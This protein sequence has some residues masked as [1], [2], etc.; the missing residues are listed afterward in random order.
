[1][2][3]GAE[4][5]TL[6]PPADEP[7]SR[8][9]RWWW[10]ALVP[11]VAFA[12]LLASGLGRD[13]SELPSEL[14]GRSAPAFSLPALSGDTNVD[15]ATLRGNVVVVNFWASWCAECRDEHPALLNAWDRYRDRGVVFV[16]VDFEDSAEDAAAYAR[17]MGGDWPLATDPGSRAAIDFGVFGVPETFVLDADGT[18]VAK[19]V[20]PV[21]YEW[22]ISAIERALGGS[23]A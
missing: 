11:V 3:A 21:D 9:S 14:V 13:P 20:G 16:G 12:L 1:V 15:L 23:A 17:E 2:T 4:G 6:E 19:Q 22:L 5:T 8:R 18:I 7:A 10:L